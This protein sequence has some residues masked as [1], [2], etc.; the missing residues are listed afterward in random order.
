MLLRNTVNDN[1]M[2]SIRET[3]LVISE[4]MSGYVINIHS[5]DDKMADYTPFVFQM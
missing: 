4:A 2:I 3:N 5:L 1:T